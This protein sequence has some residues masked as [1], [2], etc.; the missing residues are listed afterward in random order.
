MNRRYVHRGRVIDGVYQRCDDDCPKDGCRVGHKWEYSI[1]LPEIEGKRRRIY[2]SGFATG[3]DAAEARAEIVNKERKGTQPRNH[4]L[5]WPNGSP[6][7][8]NVRRICWVWAKAHLS[9]ISATFTATGSLRS[10]G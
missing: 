6:T 9:T 2:K 3:A 1:E 7:G 8:C 4:K 5:S 10:A